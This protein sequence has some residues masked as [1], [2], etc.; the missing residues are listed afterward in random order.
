MDCISY[1]CV[2]LFF[3][4]IYPNHVYSSTFSSLLSP[5][6][7][8]IIILPSLFLS[9]RSCL[10]LRFNFFVSSIVVVLRFSFSSSSSHSR[11][12]VSSLSFKLFFYSYLIFFLSLSPACLSLSLSCISSPL[13]Y[14]IL[15]YIFYSFNP[16]T[17]VLSYTHPFPSSLICLHNFLSPLSWHIQLFFNLR[18]VIHF[19]TLLFYP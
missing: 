7:F 11:S 1:S 12:S 2:Y 13:F 8:I 14:L 17:L 9:V 18:F 15:L 3:F 16:Y 4:F 10:H 6:S 19:F 5:F